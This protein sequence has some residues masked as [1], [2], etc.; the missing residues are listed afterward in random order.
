MSASIQD[1]G[2]IRDLSAAMA[3]GSLTSEALVERCLARIA[4][5]D[6]QVRAWVHVLDEE[7]LATAR[8]LDAERRAAATS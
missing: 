8:A 5:V 2:R 6:G 4:A 3:A 7:A 1:P